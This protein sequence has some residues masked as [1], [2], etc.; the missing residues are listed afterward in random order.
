MGRTAEMNQE[1]T[2]N[3]NL[4]KTCLL[5]SDWKYYYVTLVT[6]MLLLNFQI[7]VFLGPK[8][9]KKQ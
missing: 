6:S 3:Q 4:N 9:N 1:L 5:I 8:W 2:S 7:F